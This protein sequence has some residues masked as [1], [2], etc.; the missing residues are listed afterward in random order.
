MY[1]SCFSFFLTFTKEQQASLPALKLNFCHSLEDVVELYFISMNR[2][3]IVHYYLD[4]DSQL[5]LCPL[6]LR[7]FLIWN[8]LPALPL[9]AKLLA[10]QML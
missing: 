9:T 1:F 8:Y 7:G 5:C 10:V 2:S 4:V 3:K 6:Y